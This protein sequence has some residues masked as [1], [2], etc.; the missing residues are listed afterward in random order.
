[1]LIVNAVM[2]EQA[3]F[4]D[5]LERVAQEGVRLVDLQFSDLAGGA[6]A[7]TIPVDLLPGVLRNG[8]RFDGS[9]VTGGQREV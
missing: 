9:A 5:T 2:E 4:G 8:Y 3:S 6:R 1:M 7:M